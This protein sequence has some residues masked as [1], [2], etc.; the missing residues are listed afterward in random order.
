MFLFVDA[1][2]AA[3]YGVK[4]NFRHGHFKSSVGASI[5]S[6]VRDDAP[7]VAQYG[8]KIIV[9]CSHLLKVSSYTEQ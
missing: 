3:Q 4:T 8:V 1:P 2:L 6:R 9:Q 7:L 5:A